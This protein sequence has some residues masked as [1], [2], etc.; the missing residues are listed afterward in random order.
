MSALMELPQRVRDAADRDAR[1][2]RAQR[3]HM[4]PPGSGPE[5][6]TCAE[7]AHLVRLESPSGRRFHKC[8]LMRGRW[9]HGGASDIRRADPACRRFAENAA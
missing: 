7:C 8:G 1:Q 4:E 5:G 3:G 6:R 9:T 2:K